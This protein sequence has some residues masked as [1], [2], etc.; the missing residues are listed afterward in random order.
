M[1]TAK[2]GYFYGLFSLR[3][4]SLLLVLILNCNDLVKVTGYYYTI[5]LIFQQLAN[6]LQKKHTKKLSASHLRKLTTS[7]IANGH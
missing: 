1:V 4:L 3:L 7:S 2:G 5:L 6:Q